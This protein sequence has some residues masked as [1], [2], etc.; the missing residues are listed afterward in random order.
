MR[1]RIS[2]W[3]LNVGEQLLF[4][5]ERVYG[6]QLCVQH[7][8]AFFQMHHDQSLEGGH[9]VLAFRLRYPQG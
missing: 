4:R 5:G 2:S 6:H 9:R 1:P 7:L 8:I 3:N